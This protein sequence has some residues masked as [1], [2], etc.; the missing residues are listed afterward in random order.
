M[1][2]LY[3]IYRHTSPSGKVYIGITSKKNPEH[4]WNKG[5]NY[6]NTTYFYNA[7]KKYGW[8][9]IKHEILFYNVPE[10][11]AKKLEISL[12]R[13]YKNLGISYNITEG[14]EGVLGLKH[15]EE[16]KKKMSE[17]RMSK[18]TSEE[19]K[20]LSRKAGLCNKGNKYNRKTG[21]KKGYYKGCKKVSQYTPEGVLIN[22]FDSVS[23]ASD[24][25]NIPKQE[26]RRC[27]EGYRKTC[28]KFIFKY[29]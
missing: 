19:R 28:R 17:I 14:G 16:C 7:I 6:R 23:I 25:L 12:I 2:N 11:R 5:R 18:Y 24:I 21:F 20:E 13:H 15:S 26:I 29:E 22:T 27:A 4:R 9:N 8:D 3:I 10:D 1:E